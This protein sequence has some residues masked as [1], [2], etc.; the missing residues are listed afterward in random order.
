MK[1]EVER[2]DRIFNRIK[3]LYDGNSIDA[4]EFMNS[5]NRG[6]GN[7]RPIDMIYTEEDCEKVLALVG[8]L[9]HGIPS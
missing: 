9:E 8:R 2:F 7:K 4:L 1:E 6:L 3:E 5:I